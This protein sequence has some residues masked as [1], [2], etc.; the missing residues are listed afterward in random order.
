MFKKKFIL[1]CFLP[2]ISISLTGCNYVGGGINSMIK[3]PQF[4]TQQSFI[5]KALEETIGQEQSITLVSPQNGNYRSAIIMHDLDQEIDEEAIAFYQSPAQSNTEESGI[6]MC[7]LDRIDGRWKV[8]WDVP[9]AGSKVDK[10]LFY[11]DNKSNDKYIITGFIPENQGQNTYFIYKYKDKSLT[12]IASGSYQMME[13]YDING[14]G[15]ED[16]ITVGYKETEGIPNDNNLSI[17]KTTAI[18]NNIVDD[19]LV[20]IGETHMSGKAISYENI[21]QNSTS[22][23]KPS[24]I[25]DEK[26]NK[27]T[28]ATEILVYEDNNLKNLIY[29]GVDNS[30]FEQTFRAQVPISYDIDNDGTVEIPKT[31][32]FP[33]YTQ[34]SS[35]P[36]YLS[37]WRKLNGNTLD[38]NVNAYINYSQGYGFIVPDKWVE[39]VSVK[40]IDNNE[41]EFF[42]YKGDIN[43]TSDKLLDLKIETLNNQNNFPT[44]YV[45]I[46]TVGQVVYLAK[47]YDNKNKSLN[48]TVDNVKE[49]LVKMYIN[50][51]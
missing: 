10:V 30:L 9:G 34:N 43:D 6:R 25:I 40:N 42:I 3:P 20:K 13:L 31:T 26:V 39:R 33:G 50:S 29:N 8:V 32:L 7:L 5:Y 2:L 15:Q 46:D 21:K 12:N 41:I 47:V 18:A 19:K 35:S 37:K 17:Q 4:S 24:L 1:L 48:I 36:F 16:F 44:G 38:G 14:D 49:Q 27:N 28:Y 45:K 11:N 23:S 22:F 51:D